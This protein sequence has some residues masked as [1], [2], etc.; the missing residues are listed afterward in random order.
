MNDQENNLKHIKWALY[1]IVLGLGI[2]INLM[3]VN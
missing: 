2:I 3:I 1:V